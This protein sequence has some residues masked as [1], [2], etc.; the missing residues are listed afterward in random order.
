LENDALVVDVGGGVG[1]TTLQLKKVYPHLRYLVQDRPD[2][3]ADGIKVHLSVK[4][5]QFMNTN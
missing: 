2:V 1:A 3:V 4:E 5:N